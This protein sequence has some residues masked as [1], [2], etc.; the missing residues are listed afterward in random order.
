MLEIVDKNAFKIITFPIIK[1]SQLQDHH[2][3]CSAMIC[4]ICVFS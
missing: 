3:F 4:E 2:P 1:L